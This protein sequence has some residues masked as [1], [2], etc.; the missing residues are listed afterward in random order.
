MKMDALKSY[1][2]SPIPSSESE[3]SEK[4]EDNVERPFEQEVGFLIDRVFVKSFTN[5]L[6][7]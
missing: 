5:L 4:G 6:F 2:T 7:T 3:S 1:S